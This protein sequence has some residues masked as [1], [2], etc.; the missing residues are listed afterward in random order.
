MSY[1]FLCHLKV[2]FLF[3]TSRLRGSTN[4][5][6]CLLYLVQEAW[7]YNKLL[8]SY[9][10]WEFIS[11]LADKVLI[12]QTDT[13]LVSPPSGLTIRE[14]TDLNYAF[15]GAPWHM[16]T[17]TASNLWLRRMQRHGS[18]KAGFGNGGLS[19]RDVQAMLSIAQNF[20]CDIPH[21]PV[22]KGL[23]ILIQ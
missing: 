11:F 9:Q 18:L 16:T 8:K 12:F 2:R 20:G 22:G 6:Y 21:Y 4:F 13:L 3:E 7:E 23:H 10:F 1:L 17:N 14:V 19:L 5:H 15:I